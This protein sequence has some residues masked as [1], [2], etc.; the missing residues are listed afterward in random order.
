MLLSKKI[1]SK[2]LNGTLASIG[3]ILSPLSWWNDLVV[4][5][6]LSYII[7]LPFGLLNQKLFIPAFIVA[8]WLTNIIGLLLIHK[9]SQKLFNPNSQTKNQILNTFV[10]GSIYTILIIILVLSGALSFPSEFLKKIN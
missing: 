6:P 3:F 9:G 8:Y 1:T 2:L 5:F 10:W 7:A 4:N